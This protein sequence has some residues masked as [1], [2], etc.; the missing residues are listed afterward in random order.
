MALASIAGSKNTAARIVG[1]SLGTPRHGSGTLLAPV[2][3]ASATRALGR[4]FVY[5]HLRLGRCPFDVENRGFDWSSGRFRVLGGIRVE[6]VASPSSVSERSY[7]IAD[8]CSLL[9][10]LKKLNGRIA[11]GVS[12][13]QEEPAAVNTDEKAGQRQFRR[14]FPP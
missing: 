13:F 9:L 3:I 2:S 10:W 12:M 5:D 6:R 1:R 4:H 7:E 11:F 8:T 14:C